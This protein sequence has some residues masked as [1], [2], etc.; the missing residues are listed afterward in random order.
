LDDLA[1][2]IVA[3]RHALADLTHQDGR[4]VVTLVP[5]SVSMISLSHHAAESLVR[6]RHRTL[7]RQRIGDKTL[8]TES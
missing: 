2:E 7:P 1:H 4:R 6:V 3:R 5:T 8:T